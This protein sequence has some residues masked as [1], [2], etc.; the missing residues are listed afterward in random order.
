M[1]AERLLAGAHWPDDWA[2]A[3]FALARDGR[4]DQA[5]LRLVDAWLRFRAASGSA[6]PATEDFLAWGG[7]ANLKRLEAALGVLG[8]RDAKR[9]LRAEQWRR[10]KAAQPL[11]ARSRQ[12]AASVDADALPR[13]W[14]RALREMRLAASERDDDVV[15]LDARRVY[16]PRSI[17]RMEHTL[18]QL[19]L[20]SCRVGLEPAISPPC[21]D[22]L[23]RALAA[24]GRRAATKAA[25]CKELVLFGL[26]IEAEPA[27]LDHARCRRADFERQAGGQRKRKDEWLLT[28]D[29]HVGDVYLHA[30]RL[31]AQAD[32]LPP[33]QD[34]TLH[35]RLEAAAIGLSVNAPLRIGDLH[36]LVVGQDV[37]RDAEG[38]RLAT[39]TRK[40]GAMYDAGRLWPEVEAMLDTL[41]LDGHPPGDFWRRLEARDGTPLF[42]LDDGRTGVA[43]EWP[44]RVWRRHFGI[45][46]HIIR[47]L[48]HMVCHLEEPESA[49]AALAQCGQR[50][51]RTA[52]HYLVRVGRRLAARKG[53]RM[54]Q[55]VRARLLT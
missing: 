35:R 1:S 31:A 18:C 43:V 45:G 42:S 39:R 53:Q 49:W 55:G 20:E 33:Q 15:A 46:E 47:S 10:E 40:T 7:L 36:R 16:A 13:A 23:V 14:Q 25:R 30:Q 2:S 37:V 3:A 38:W 52:Q 21:V 32:A 4:A 54:L 17:D 48:W 28:H 44:S 50:S 24:R 22:A 27:A 5:Q 29:L 34:R 9:R 26:W 8:L 6:V 19:A 51:G 12:R 11:P 41:I